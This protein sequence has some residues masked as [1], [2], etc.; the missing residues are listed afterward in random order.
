MRF[1]PIGNDQI[2]AQL[3]LQPAAFLSSSVFGTSQSPASLAAFIK[4]ICELQVAGTSGKLPQEI[5]VTASC[6]RSQE[7]QLKIK[8]H[9]K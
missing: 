6:A 9:V 2:N 8:P 3:H 1:N 4:T 5:L 7:I